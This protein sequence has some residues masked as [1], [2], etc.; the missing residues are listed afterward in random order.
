MLDKQ[1]EQ[2]LS[3]RKLYHVLGRFTSS[4][5]PAQF[6]FHMNIIRPQS[7]SIYMTPLA[8]LY[9]I[10]F[11]QTDTAEGEVLFTLTLN[12][13]GKWILPLQ[14]MSQYSVTMGT[15]AAV[16]LL[17]AAVWGLLLSYILQIRWYF[18]GDFIIQCNTLQCLTV[19]LALPFITHLSTT[20]SKPT[21]APTMTVTH[22]L[23]FQAERYLPTFPTQYSLLGSR[24]ASSKCKEILWCLWHHCK[25][26]W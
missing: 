18:L 17:Q 8:L 10:S 14:K 23:S 6:Y 20:P 21:V 15:C 26:R 12:C 5:D 11:C 24:F 16:W 2:H 25:E 3:W 4:D 13:P 1:E 22:S 7:H 9:F 19:S